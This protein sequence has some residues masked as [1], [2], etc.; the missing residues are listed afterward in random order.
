M[1]NLLVIIGLLLT[2][3]FAVANEK[4]ETQ[5]EEQWI[6]TGTG[7]INMGGPAGPIIMHVQGRGPTQIAAMS[8]AQSRCFS[9]GLQMCMI[10]NCYKK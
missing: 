9:Q 2:T 4:V 8:D 7:T 3:S 5:K 1:K 6:C 10:N